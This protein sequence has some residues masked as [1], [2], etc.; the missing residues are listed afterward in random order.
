[1]L[2]IIREQ[3]A[4]HNP[5]PIQIGEVISP[6]PN[7]KIRVGDL[8]LDRD[9]V[10]IA[11][12]LLADYARQIEL[13][14]VTLQSTLSTVAEHTHTIDSFQINQANLKLKDTLKTGDLV[15][16]LATAD[17]QTFIVLCKVVKT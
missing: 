10:L 16:L 15:A 1:M 4:Y 2:K 8:Q 11:D 14:N 3:G 6:P 7:I 9:D 13:K 5:P 17:R 12:Y